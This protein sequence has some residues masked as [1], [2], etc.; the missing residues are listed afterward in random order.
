M[1]Y[2]IGGRI[3]ETERLLTLNVEEFRSLNLFPRIGV[4]PF[5]QSLNHVRCI[6]ATKCMKI[7]L[8][9]LLFSHPDKLIWNQT[10]LCATWRYMSKYRPK[11]VLET[12]SNKQ[13]MRTMGPAKV[14]L[15]SPDNYLKKRSKEPKLPDSKFVCRQTVTGT[16]SCFN[17]CET[18]IHSRKW[19][20][21]ESESHLHWQETACPREDSSSIDGH[22]YEEGLHQDS[23]NWAHEATACQCELHQGRQAASREFRAC[24]QVLQ[25]EGNF[26]VPKVFVHMNN[27]IILPMLMW[28]EVNTS[29][30]FLQHFGKLP[31]YL[32]KR[33][34]DEQKALEEYN[35]FLKE[36]REQAAM[37]HVSIEK[38]KSLLKVNKHWPGSQSAMEPVRNKCRS[39]IGISQFPSLL[40][41]S[42][43]WGERGTSCTASTRRSRSSSTPCRRRPARSTWS[44]KW[45]SW[46]MT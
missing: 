12:K 40:W 27:Y 44:L 39:D 15:P 19:A 36:Q 1:T 21:Y 23:H 3:W 14:E 37:T 16:G 28:K 41:M 42:R 2:W 4:L 29:S 7:T 45:C 20:V 10:V 26:S 22:C 30:C 17:C 5:Q 43:V 33:I 9:C 31:K 24:S 34:D 35:N 32:Q 13:A 6:T 25:K 18:L 8:L 38:R 46:R 11:V